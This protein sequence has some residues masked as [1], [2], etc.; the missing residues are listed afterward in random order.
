[1]DRAGVVV[2]AGLREAQ[3]E[4]AAGERPGPEQPREREA[5]RVVTARLDVRRAEHLG[6]LRTEDL[7]EGDRVGLEAVVDPGHGVTGRHAGPGRVELVDAHPLADG[8]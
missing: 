2:L 4:R 1:M 6:R 3:R 7:A 8:T 5:A